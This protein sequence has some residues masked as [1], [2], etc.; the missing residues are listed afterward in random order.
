[1][2]IYGDSFAMFKNWIPRLADVRFGGMKYNAASD[3]YEWGR[4]RTV[5]S[6]LSPNVFKSLK[7][8]RSAMVAND[9]GVT[10]MR[11]SY[12]K[13]KQEYERETGKKFKMTETQ[14]MDMYRRNVRN[15]M[16]DAMAI[17]S[18]LSI[19]VALKANAPD[20]DEDEAVKNQYKFLLRA[21]DKLK[22][23][24][25]YFYDPSSFAQLISSGLFPSLQLI[26]NFEKIL[27]NFLK[28]NYGLLIGDEE[29]MKSAHTFKYI[30]KEFPVT[31]QMQQYLP[32]FYP[33]LAKDLG[34]QVQ[35]TSG[36][37]R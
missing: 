3:A 28:Y 37:I 36:F 26:T 31:N 8:L 5:F 9:E 27:E 30:M 12:E 35:S 7:K 1:M 33:D 25:T 19:I 16:W 14:F 24:L 17:I 34:I 4:L 22:D 10:A 2:T 15:T 6:E 32:L 21:A 13:K 11:E 20:D 29:K 18:L 23:E